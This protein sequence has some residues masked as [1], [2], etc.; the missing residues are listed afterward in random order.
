MMPIKIALCE[1]N[2][3]YRESLQ[4]YIVETPGWTVTASL[5]DALDIVDCLRENTPHVL[6]MD[7]DLPG[8]NG[9]EAT[10]LVK[11]TYPEVHVLML[12]VY[13]DEEKIFKAL[14]V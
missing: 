1:D 10:A 9:I 12:T 13:E 8:V 6:L 5:R 11:A 4:Q 2:D 7:I 3:S 14:Q